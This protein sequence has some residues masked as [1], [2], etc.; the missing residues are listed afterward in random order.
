MASPLMELEDE[1][2]E[3][4]PVWKEEDGD[5]EDP[6]DHPVCP[7]LGRHAGGSMC[8]QK[9]LKK[10]M[11]VNDHIDEEMAAKAK[12]GDWYEVDPPCDKCHQSGLDCYKFF[13][14]GQ[15]MWHKLCANCYEKKTLCSIIQR[16]KDG[17]KTKP[18]PKNDK[19]KGRAKA[20]SDKDEPKKDKGKEKV[21]VN[22][23]DDGTHGGD[24][25][26]GNTADRKGKRKAEEAGAL[27][28]ESIPPAVKKRKV[29]IEQRE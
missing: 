15:F 24:G 5:F 4:D 6:V 3:D 23:R 9:K 20:D 29:K 21:K 10:T 27:D 8:H 25:D 12:E 1:E 17:A 13:R 18:E 11:I 7:A 26:T 2:D 28:E 14:I 19:G 16:N 22:D